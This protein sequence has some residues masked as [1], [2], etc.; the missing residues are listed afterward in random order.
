LVFGISKPK[1]PILGSELSGVVESVGTNVTQFKPGDAVFAFSDAAMGCHAAYKC[2]S[3]NSAIALKPS[4]LSFEEAAALSFG[5]TTALHYIRKA[6]LQRGDK[7]LIIGA[8]G[9]VGT[10]AVQLARHFGA[11]VT[12]VCSAAN[13]DLVRGLGAKHVI[14]YTQEDYTLNA[15]TYDVILDTTG[16]ASYTRCKTSLKENGRFLMLVA[17]LPQMLQIPWVNLTSNKKI[18][19]GTASGTADD[20]RFLAELAQ[21]GQFIPVIDTQYP[22]EQIVDAH[23][24]VDS[25]RKKGNIVLLMALGH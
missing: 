3:Q 19:A 9:S 14:D 24:H 21:T 2:M 17:S 11:E 13:S 5:G 16:T 18:I 15:E 1:Q 23:R 7:I 10:A 20:L 22:F 12:G 8:S 4:T 6:K 25:G